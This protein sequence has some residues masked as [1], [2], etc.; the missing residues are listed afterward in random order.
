M[1]DEANFVAEEQAKPSKPVRKTNYFK[2]LYDIDVSE[3]A[4]E[5]N[6]LSY[7]PWAC[8]W[9][10]VKKKF[11]D[12][13]YTVYENADGKFWFDDG[14]TGW[15]KTGVTINGIEA[16][17]RLPIM[18]NRNKSI[19]AENI[20]STD[21]NKAVQRSITKACGRHGLGLYLYEGEDIPESVSELVELNDNNFKLT[22][23]IAKAKPEIKA[24]LLE[25]IKKYAPN[26][27]PKAVKSLDDAKELNKELYGMKG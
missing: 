2:T 20:K 18:D 27:N 23:A 1:N 25:V 4:E 15:V 11:P 19:E 22:A 9:A 8:A 7:L 24:D 5:K 6:G 17:E 16:I 13:T 3:K 12:A 21:A 14:R 10:E 26:G